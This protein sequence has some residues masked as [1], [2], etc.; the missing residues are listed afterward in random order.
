M[1]NSVLTASTYTPADAGEQQRNNA[2]RILVETLRDMNRFPWSNNGN[3]NNVDGPNQE[4]YA[5]FMQG[6]AH[7]FEPDSEE[8]NMLLKSAFRECCQKGLLNSIIWDK[9]CSAIRPELAKTFIGDIISSSEIELDYEDLPEEWSSS[10]P[11]R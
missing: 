1:Y 6:C 7:L 2:A 10:G 8:R 5:L 9:F 11:K 4:S 3:T